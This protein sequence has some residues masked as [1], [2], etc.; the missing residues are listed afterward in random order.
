VT[1]IIAVIVNQKTTEWGG[2]DVNKPSPPA[3]TRSLQKGNLS[4]GTGDVWRIVR[5]FHRTQQ[6]EKKLEIGVTKS[7]GN[8]LKI[9]VEINKCSRMGWKRGIKKPGKGR[10]EGW[11]SL[12]RRENGGGDRDMLNTAPCDQTKPVLT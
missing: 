2:K 7:P 6:Q 12:S 3:P 1:R 10:E 9:I 4:M 5:G 8:G 11:R